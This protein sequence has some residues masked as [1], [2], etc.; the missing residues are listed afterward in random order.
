MQQLVDRSSP[1]LMPTPETVYITATPASPSAAPV[2][3]PIVV[4]A[5]NTPAPAPAPAVPTD[6]PTL[7]TATAGEIRAEAAVRPTASTLQGEVGG[8]PYTVSEDRLCV[9]TRRKSD[10]LMVRECQ[11]Y[12]YTEGEARAVA[13]Y[14]RAGMIQG[15]VVQ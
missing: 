7:P 6:A 15:E 10:E 11:S 1:M 9:Q 14:L 2:V 5:T 13:Q 4:F 3:A 8:I 12:A